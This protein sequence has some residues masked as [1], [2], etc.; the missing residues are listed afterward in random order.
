M[1]DKIFIGWSGTNEYAVAVANKLNDLGYNSIVGGN[2]EEPNSLFIG[3][4]IISQMNECS[5]AIFLF[6]KKKQTEQISS[7]LFFEFGYMANKLTCKK[8]FVYYIDITENDMLIPS[9]LRGLWTTGFL[10]SE[11]SDKL[12]QTVTESFVKS[13]KH[14]IEGYKIDIICNW[15]KFKNILET[16]LTTQQ[17]STFEIAQYLLFYTQAV[18]FND[19]F[20]E[21]NML[22][23]KFFACTSSSCTE[24]SIILRYC[25][26][27]FNLYR[28]FFSKTNNILNKSET[29]EIVYK[30]D[31]LLDDCNELNDSEFKYWLNASLHENIGFTLYHYLMNSIEVQDLDLCKRI[32]DHNNQALHSLN[33]L[34]N[35]FYASHNNNDFAN[36]LKAYVY[37][38]SEFAYAY[39]TH[40][41]GIDCDN[42]KKV[43]AIN[44][45][46]TWKLLHNNFC[47]LKTNPKFADNVELNYYLTMSKILDID[48]YANKRQR[49]YEQIAS[50]LERQQNNC[51][52]ITDYLNIIRRNISK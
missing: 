32:L 43:S 51:N 4:T 3:S 31:D 22:V 12:V 15:N 40:K 52:T 13:Q 35:G 38:Q 9:D 47:N 23:D 11:D 46:E 14:I 10:L 20:D 37:T 7:N 42:N 18:Y 29:L 26:Q 8:I 16:Y 5:Q 45:F 24:L 28:K 1:Q 44:A 19:D 39:M 50:Y 21:T 30:F 25:K 41:S 2:N 34:T 17:C 49:Y 33:I 27:C 6:Q 36:L 48:K